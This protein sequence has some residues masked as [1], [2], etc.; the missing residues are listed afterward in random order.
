MWSKSDAMSHGRSF[1]LMRD[2]AA[3]AGKPA[4]RLFRW[5]IQRTARFVTFAR[6]RAVQNYVISPSQLSKSDSASQKRS[7]NP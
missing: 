3:K 4:K 6:G 7:F 1:A 2:R 5:L